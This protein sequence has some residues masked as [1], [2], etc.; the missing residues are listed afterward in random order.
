MAGRTVEAAEG[1]KGVEN[2]ADVRA[3]LQV[4]F[5]GTEVTVP[6]HGPAKGQA[7]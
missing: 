7:V 6:R 4:T 2:V 1:P 5:V 3:P